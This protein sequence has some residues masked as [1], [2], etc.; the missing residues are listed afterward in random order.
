M[1]EKKRFI[2]KRYKGLSNKEFQS[3]RPHLYWQTQKALPTWNDLA[4]AGSHWY[5]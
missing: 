5:P 1:L 4:F 2:P 3:R